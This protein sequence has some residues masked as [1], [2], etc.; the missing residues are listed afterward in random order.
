MLRKWYA[1]VIG[2]ALLEDKPL[3]P[4][5]DRLAALLEAA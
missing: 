4:K 3:M 5:V 2:R 1:T